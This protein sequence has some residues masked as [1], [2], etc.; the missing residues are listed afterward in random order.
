[1]DLPSRQ[2]LT[3]LAIEESSNQV[4]PEEGNMNGDWN[5]YTKTGEV[6]RSR[7]S[8]QH[9][10]AGLCE[11]CC[12]RHVTRDAAKCSALIEITIDMTWRA[13]TTGNF[14]INGVDLRAI[15]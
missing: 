13:G 11:A 5:N 15:T 9:E 3:Q 7:N 6:D 8:L 10:K 14:L 2:L 4:E 1:M 12:K